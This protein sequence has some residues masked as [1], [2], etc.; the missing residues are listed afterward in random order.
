MN[1]VNQ[2]IGNLFIISKYTKNGRQY[3]SCLCDCGNRIE[4]RKDL[5]LKR[6]DLSCGCKTKINYND[7]IRKNIIDFLF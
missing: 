6:K 4:I 1:L 5:I 7:I 2:K 3:Y